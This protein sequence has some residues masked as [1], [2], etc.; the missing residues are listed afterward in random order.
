[1]LGQME[2]LQIPGAAVGVPNDKQQLVSCYGVTNAEHPLPITEATFFQIGS[3]T[4][5]FTG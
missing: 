3:I 2:T 4:K 1:M 5:T